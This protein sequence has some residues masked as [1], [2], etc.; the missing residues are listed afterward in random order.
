MRRALVVFASFMFFALSAPV[1]PALPAE[2]LDKGLMFGGQ[3][4]DANNT[5]T[6]LSNLTDLPAVVEVYT[7]TWCENCV[8]VEH[9]L[10]EVQDAGLI[11][12]YHI[13]RAIGETQ[14]PFGSEA[15]DSRWN[16]KYGQNAPPAVVFNGTMKKSGSVTSEASLADEF[17]TLANNDLALGD[18]STTFG[19]TPTTASSGTITWNLDIDNSHL[20]N[21]TLNVTAW[22]VEAAAEFEEGSNGLGTYPHIVLDIISL[23]DALQGSV[24]IQLPNANDG[25]DLQVHLIYEIMPEIVEPVAGEEV[26][27]AEDS[28]SVPFLTTLATATTL[29]GAAWAHG[30]KI[31]Q[32]YHQGRR[33]Q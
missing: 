23:G 18:G 4:S 29:L 32:R 14:D 16:A 27:V 17:T 33:M 7:A 24:A 25:N 20:E 15:I 8:D 1:A 31:N 2:S 26:K 5:T 11:E 13:H 10:D 21:S 28:E 30:G 19:W 12:Q 3:W 9:A 6:D 22:I